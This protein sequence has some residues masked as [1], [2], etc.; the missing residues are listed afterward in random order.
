MRIG[1]I[2]AVAAGALVIAAPAEAAKGTYA[3][4]VTNTTG[5]IA[6]DVKIQQG[7]VTKITHLRGK[8]IPSNCEVSGQIPSVNFDLASNIAVNQQTAKFKGNY[9]QPTYGNVSTI[10]GTFFGNTVEG[11]VDVN[12]H[13][14]AEG[15][16]PEENC[17]TGKLTFKAKF[18][19]P[20]GTQTQSRPNWR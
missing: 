15:Q 9:T 19:A 7:S 16:Y 17:D 20:D 6:L 1:L 14:Q 11:K 5:K 12:F 10:K 8:G 18:G 2:A 13:Y 3:G 4:S